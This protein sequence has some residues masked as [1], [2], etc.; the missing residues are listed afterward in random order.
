MPS[1][2]PAP[3]PV[4]LDLPSPA[5]L[6]KTTS[7]KKAISFSSPTKLKDNEP[8]QLG[9]GTSVEKGAGKVKTL[10][11][12][13]GAHKKNLSSSSLS[14]SDDKPL[15]A[16]PSDQSVT[17]TPSKEPLRADNGQASS[18]VQTVYP[19]YASDADLFRQSMESAQRTVSRLAVVDT[20]LTG[21]GVGLSLGFGWLPGVEGAV[22][23]VE[24]M[25]DQAKMISVGR[26]AALRLVS[27][28]LV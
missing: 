10:L 2:P 21:L 22:K 3:F 20:L 17:P 24:Q 23:L 18:T 5:P 27:L 12:K 6:S 15:A 28:H 7:H 9:K 19:T 26:V 1:P 8:D 16:P 25:L 14:S 4:N 13:L 11:G